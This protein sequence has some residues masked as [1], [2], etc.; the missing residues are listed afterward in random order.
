MPGNPRSGYKGAEQ[1]IQWGKY[2]CEWIETCFFDRAEKLKPC[3][4]G[5]RGAC[6]KHCHMGP[7]RF[8]QGSEERVERGGC[9]ATM[10]TV[11]ARNLLRMAAS[12]AAVH[13]AHARDMVY[14]L[15]GVA[16]GEIR[17]FVIS[18]VKRLYS[19]A[20]TIGIVTGGRQIK[21]IA[22]DVAEGLIADFERHDGVLSY[23]RTAPKKTQEMWQKWG[24][25]PGGIDREI[26][27]AIYR[28]NM[29]VDHDP[30]SLLMSA[31]KVS[32]A[33]GWGSSMIASDITGILLGASQPVRT[34]GGLGVFREDAVNVVVIGDDPTLMAIITDTASEP[35]TIEYARSR[36][37]TGITVGD[38]FCMRPGVP[39]A[40]GFTN[41]EICI[42]TGLI[43]A[44][45]AGAHRLMPTLVEVASGF[46]TKI[47]TT[48]QRGRLPGAIHIP[49]DIRRARDVAREI[50]RLAIDNYPNRTGMGE[51]VTDRY[52]VMAG[53]NEWQ[54]LRHAIDTPIRRLNAA[55]TDGR[56]RGIV[57]IV[58]SDNPRFEA[59]GIHRYL[60]RELIG[61]D[62]L[63]LSTDCCSAACAISGY[64]DPETIFEMAGSGLRKA[65]REIGIPPVIHLGSSLDNSRILTI[66][67]AMAEEWGLPEGIA[68]LP[69]TV[70]APE[71][72]AETEVTFGCYFAASGISVILGG[73]SP[74]EASEEVAGI[75]T[76]AWF[77]RFG[78]SLHFEPDP[79][80]MY[81][82]AIENID[83]RR[84]RIKLGEYEYGWH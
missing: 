13:A 21:D 38:I 41:Q 28:T 12:G 22:R 37:A 44:V 6:C 10:A 2:Y 42:M 25:T 50:L 43:D 39:I 84:E 11:A 58:G 46:H 59:T 78:G 80:R 40:G 35:D 29:G 31:L 52:P 23:V 51:R 72:F 70:I 68:G 3:P 47:I 54:S 27:E 75:M 24:I 20:E 53:G 7:C 79:E 4:T 30:D 61:D 17:D 14:T 48:S 5:A 26:V 34:D 74:V 60:V 45:I 19:M 82:L 1:I 64:L 36:G 77:E 76:D 67:S 8:V 18:D 9:G 65:C 33:D 66:L 56:I 62:V 57:G 73:I 55:I 71:W 69:V 49:Y 15:L 83:R 81:I 16:N 63:V 32:L